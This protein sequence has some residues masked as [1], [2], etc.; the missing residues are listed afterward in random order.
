MDNT[1]VILERKEANQGIG[2]VEGNIILVAL[3]RGVKLTA[4]EYVTWFENTDG[5]TFSGHYTVD[6]TDALND[7]NNR[8]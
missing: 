8:S 6:L 2:Q 1:R 3:C 5:D 7:F 4:V